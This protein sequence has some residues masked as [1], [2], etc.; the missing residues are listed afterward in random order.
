MNDCV[1]PKSDFISDASIP[2]YA[3]NWN[4]DFEFPQTDWPYQLANKERLHFF[5]LSYNLFYRITYINFS[6]FYDNFF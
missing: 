5:K 4:V 3:F 6:I 2:I 1:R